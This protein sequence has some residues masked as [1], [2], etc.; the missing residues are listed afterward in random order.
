MKSLHSYPGLPGGQGPK[1][2]GLQEG[3]SSGFSFCCSWV[4]HFSAELGGDVL[5]FLAEA[6]RSCPSARRTPVE[7]GPELGCEEVPVCCLC[8]FRCPAPAV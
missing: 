3:G 6:L 4:A 8:L 7:V 2:E 5:P 1:E